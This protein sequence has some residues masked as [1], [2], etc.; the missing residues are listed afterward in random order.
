[1]RISLLLLLAGLTF[2]AGHGFAQ[3]S[4]GYGFLGGTFGG[5]GIG[6]AFRYGMG[7]EWA[8]APRVMLGAEVGGIEKDGSGVVASAN[9]AYH[10]PV[11]SYGNRLDPF[12]TGGVSIAHLRDT[13]LFLNLGGG[14]NYWFQRRLGFRVELRGYPGGQDLNSFGEFRMGVVF[15]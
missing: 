4:F 7:G 1:M 9:A 6:G 11:R 8:V 2:G 14:V 15:R 10:I 3:Q 5:R 13:G 12:V